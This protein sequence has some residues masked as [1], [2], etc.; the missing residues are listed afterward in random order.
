[1][2]LVSPR[3]EPKKCFELCSLYSFCVI[4]WQR[5]RE[6]RGERERERAR[7]RERESEREGEGGR[8]E[9]G[10]RDRGVAGGEERHPLQV[11]T[12]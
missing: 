3:N 2:F 10:E 7:E 4:V 8:E 1:M 6:R 5:E 12:S 9:E 11:S